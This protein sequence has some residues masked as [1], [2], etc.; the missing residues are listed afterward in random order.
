MAIPGDVN[1]CLAGAK[2]SCTP[3]I[4]DNIKNFMDYTD[5]S[6]EFTPCQGG[7][8]MEAWSW[9]MGREFAEGVQPNLS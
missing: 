2:E 3:G 6:S 1:S 9:R 7:R 5:C 4:K 8:M